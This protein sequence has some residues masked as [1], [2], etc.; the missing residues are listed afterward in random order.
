MWLSS[1]GTLVLSFMETPFSGPAP[2]PGLPAGRVLRPLVEHGLQGWDDGVARVSC[3]KFTTGSFS[4]P[5]AVIGSGD[6]M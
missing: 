6:L 3:G 1:C 5:E 4:F 2:K